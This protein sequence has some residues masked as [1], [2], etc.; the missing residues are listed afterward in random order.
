[1]TPRP[2]VSVVV[3]TYNSAADVTD[4]LSALPGAAATTSYE[5]VVVDNASMDDSAATVRRTL[6]T[7]VLVEQTD[8]TGF[9]AACNVGVKASTGEYVLLLNPDA[10]PQ[11]GSI[12]ALV[13]FA[14]RHPDHTPL[15]GRCVDEAGGLDPRS[16]WGAPTL[17]STLC[18][19]TGVARWRKDSP[20]LN[21]EGLGGWQR[22]SVREVGV[23]T[24]FLLLVQR[25]VW[26]ELHGLDRTF[27]VYGEDVDFSVRA[28]RAGRRPSITPD[29]LVV[30]PAGKSSPDSLSKLLL[31]Y[32]GK[33]TFMLKHWSRPRA[34]LGRLLLLLGVGLRASVAG[35]SSD[36]HQ[37]WQ[38]RREW[39]PGFT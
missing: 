34:V 13:D 22:D 9:A 20:L 31:L 11:P 14:R 2:C 15:G 36:H 5:V 27:F 18:F 7:A 17:W 1:M 12:D 26:D 10:V 4:C 16:C 3:V 8:N 21:P 32:K 25:E 30:H 23:V 24:G 35:R 33:A 39:L 38:H 37:L 19:A 28:R 29:A 6:P